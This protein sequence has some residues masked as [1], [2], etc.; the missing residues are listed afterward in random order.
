[1]TER[2]GRAIKSSTSTVNSLLSG[3]M[4]VQMLAVGT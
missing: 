4:Y 3:I 2:G 1:M